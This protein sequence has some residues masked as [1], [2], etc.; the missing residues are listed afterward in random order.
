MTE[1]RSEA[2]DTIGALY[3]AFGRA[4]L[5]MALHS[6]RS[7]RRTN[8]AMPACI[9]TNVRD[10][11]P[12]VAWWRPGE[13]HWTFLDMDTRD[14][15]RIKTALAQYTPF[16]KTIYLDCD[17]EVLR[18]LSEL[19]WFL[20]Y[21][22]LCLRLREGGLRGGHTVLNGKAVIGDLPRWNSGVMCFRQGERIRTFFEHWS[23]SYARLGEPA[24]QISLVEAIFVSECRVLSLD[25]RW[26]SGLGNVMRD[27]K[28][29]I[30]ILHYTSDHSRRLR[31]DLLEVD[32]EL[33]RQGFPEQGVSLQDHVARGRN[34]RMRKETWPRYASERLKRGALGLLRQWRGASGAS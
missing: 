19:T 1:R 4:Y 5:S 29:T 2:S 13:D 17:T 21:F 26:N 34:W 15:R 33:Q 12:D 23:R 7:L 25:N 32:R 24:D 3:L 14:N 11:A 20:D 22:D 10:R 28:G 27:A 18:D 30:R 16:D 9:I 8:P 31:R 6:V